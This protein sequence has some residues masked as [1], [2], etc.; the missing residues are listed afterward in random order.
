M[1]I[2]LGEWRPKLEAVRAEK[3]AQVQAKLAEVRV[4]LAK[5]EGK[6]VAL[7]GERAERAARGVKRRVEQIARLEGK[8]AKLAGDFSV[9]AELRKHKAAITRKARAEALGFHE[10]AGDQVVG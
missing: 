5:A 2:D 10:S 1:E 9:D 7:T 6:R 3:L 8:A 4:K